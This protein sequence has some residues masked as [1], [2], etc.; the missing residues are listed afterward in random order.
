MSARVAALALACILVARP[1]AAQ[2]PRF[3]D[4]EAD[5]SRARFRSA[6]PGRGEALSGL[7]LGVRAR[8]SFR[9]VSLE[10]SYAQGRLSA[11]EG[12]GPSRSVV[13]G[14]LFVSTLP[15]PWL[16]L[17]AGPQLRA[18][19]A[20]GGTERWVMWE[21]RAR[22]ETPI[23]SP[24]LSLRAHVEVW[25]ALVSSVNADPGAAGAR[26]GQAGMVMGLP[27]SPLWLR[28][29]YAVDQVKMKDNA[30]TEAL[31]AVV[32]TIGLGGR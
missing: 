31:E 1:L 5:L 14:S 19:V 7:V 24:A 20:P 30:R 18:Y 10:A 32:L 27:R 12:S 21:F 23:A 9:A 17:K 2:G 6:V 28:L 4:V 13:D 3:V 11:G 15:V 22:A 25:A 29:S 16:T 8:T 26:G